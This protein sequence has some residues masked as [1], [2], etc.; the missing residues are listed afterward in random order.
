M[1]NSQL[2]DFPSD[3]ISIGSLKISPLFH[4][5]DRYAATFAR[6]FL[7]SPSRNASMGE[8][9]LSVVYKTILYNYASASHFSYTSSLMLCQDGPAANK[10]DLLVVR[11]IVGYIYWIG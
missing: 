2:P 4:K 3:D 7:S 1:V 10:I 6:D 5:S 9:P 11:K 8:S